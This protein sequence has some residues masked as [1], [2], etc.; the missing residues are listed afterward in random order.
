MRDTEHHEDK[1]T[2]LFEGKWAG[3]EEGQERRKNCWTTIS[4]KKLYNLLR[5]S[6]I[7]NASSYISVECLGCPGLSYN[8]H[9]E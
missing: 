7:S 5:D 4:N 6:L 3:G 2:C 9:E 1:W 8:S